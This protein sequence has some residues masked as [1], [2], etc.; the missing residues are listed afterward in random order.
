MTTFWI[1]CAVLLAVALLFV[2]LPL[3]RST[4]K[5]NLVQRDTANLEIFRDQLAEMDA[6]LRNGLLTPELYEQGKR[7]LQAR[8][9]D[10]VKTAGGGGTLAVR[11]PQKLMALVLVALFPLA[12]VGLYWELGN[13]DAFQPQAYVANTNEMGGPH[14]TAV[15]QELED[16]LAKDP[17]DAQGWALLAR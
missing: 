11:N 9:L 15:L 5:N 16:K 10:E 7:E 14:S 12:A 13:F 4:V 2:V 6:D 8:L 17:Q 1:I 3:W